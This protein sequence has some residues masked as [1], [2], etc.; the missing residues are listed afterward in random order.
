MREKLQRVKF[1]TIFIGVEQS[2]EER[3]TSTGEDRK[4]FTA[5]AA[6]CTLAT[7]HGES[8]YDLNAFSTHLWLSGGI[9]CQDAQSVRAFASH[10]CAFASIT[11]GAANRGYR[12]RSRRRLDIRRCYITHSA[13]A[14]DVTLSFLRTAVDGQGLER[15]SSL[16]VPGR[17]ADLPDSAGGIASTSGRSKRD[18]INLHYLSDGGAEASHRPAL[19]TIAAGGD[20]LLLPI[21]DASEAADDVPPE[22]P[23][24][25]GTIEQGIAA[26]AWSPDDELLVI[27]TCETSE[28]AS[29]SGA[30]EVEKVLLMTRDFEVLSE[31]RLRT[32]EF[33]EDEAV[34]VGWG[35]KATQFHGSEGKAAAAA[36]AQA[37]AAAK[38]SNT[39]TRGPRTPDD[40]GAPR[41]SWRGDGAFFA[42]SSLEP[43]YSPDAPTSWHRVIRIY[44][45]TAA[46]SATSDAG[47][48]G[49]S[50]ALA[51]RPI[52]NL[53]ASTQRFGASD[54]DGHMWAQGRRGRHDV[55][56]FERNGLRHGEFSLREEAASQ[57]DGVQ[58]GWN[59]AQ[60]LSAWTRTHAVRELAWNADGSALA[61]WLSRA[62]EGDEARDVVQVYT[63]GNYHWYLKQE[64]VAT[65]RVEHVKWHPEDPLQLLVAHAGSVA[66]RVFAHE[67]AVSPG[68]PPVDAACVAVADGSATLLTP[69]R[70]QNVPPPMASLSLC[71]PPAGAEVK[72]S[73]A[74]VLAVPTHVAWSQ[75]PARRRN[76]PSESWLCSSK[77]AGC[78][79]GA[80]TG[81]CLAAR[82]RSAVSPWPSPSS[83]LRRRWRLRMHTRLL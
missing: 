33:G 65:T 46:L 7:T 37:A 20:L 11:A 61:V 8:A 60:K 58:L 70:M 68:R 14:P 31:V 15:F 55:V 5:A 1:E 34:D 10:H 75:L 81:A 25:V 42:I 74:S 3:C 24:V 32:D 2:R 12:Q 29:T 17:L 57:P 4:K 80:S 22:E 44:S 41:I 39:D 49:I 64:F 30:R 78:R 23:V 72:P 59:E 16:L 77:T 38:A 66:H 48:R 82:S 21:P 43:F 52:G 56:F 51:F 27:V 63:T 19:C 71:V 79:S 62:G 18:V 76:T 47:V 69:F 26:A 40:D 83:W 6:T 54:L 67:T 50:Q 36:A 13:G 28:T 35:S 53:I 9:E 73:A 45:R